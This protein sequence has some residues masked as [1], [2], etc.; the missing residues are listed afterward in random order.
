[1]LISHKNKFIYS[2]ATKTGS[3]SAQ[4]ALAEAGITGP[5]DVISGYKN[6]PKEGFLG[7]PQ[8][9]P[10][11][12][13][14]DYLSFSPYGVPEDF[15]NQKLPNAGA[16]VFTGHLTP[17]EMVLSGLVT[18]DQLFS[19]EVFGFIREPVDRWFSAYF[20]ESS[21]VGRNKDPM[22]DILERIENDNMYIQVFLD[23]PMSSWFTYQGE[24]VGK[25]YDFKSIDKVLKDLIERKGGQFSGTP[26]LKS[27]YRPDGFKR[28]TAELLS[29]SHLKKLEEYLS[30][31]I[32]FYQDHVLTK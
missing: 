26:R 18:E 24:Q 23:R 9:I 11:W 6:D 12:S 2:R 13:L 14:E 29:S 31:D 3:S 30:D 4:A 1:M 10:N 16:H 21:L 28:P 8:N 19:Y 15:Q 27:H 32:V 5:E 7:K 22:E 20:F 25:A 17:E